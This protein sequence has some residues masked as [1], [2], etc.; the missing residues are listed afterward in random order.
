M[1]Y[2]KNVTLNSKSFKFSIPD[3]NNSANPF[4]NKF[5]VIIIQSKIDVNY[6]HFGFG[7]SRKFRSI[8]D[9]VITVDIKLTMFT[10]FKEVTDLRQ[11]SY[12]CSV[13]NCQ[14][15]IYKHLCCYERN[16]KH[17]DANILRGPLNFR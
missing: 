1:I 13:W 6:L 4:M 12:K 5:V 2:I 11:L 15:G 3:D 7:C 16:H 8:A 17:A 10:L 9:N 14:P